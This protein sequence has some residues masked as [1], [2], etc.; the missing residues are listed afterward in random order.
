M[1]ERSIARGMDEVNRLSDVLLLPKMVREEAAIIYR[2]AVKAGLIRG[3]TVLA[4]AAASV[5]AA[6]R[7]RGFRGALRRLRA[8]ARPR[9]RRCG[10]AIGQ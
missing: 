2:R 5:Y 7:L 9:R 1:K 3:R 4:M 8:P 10:G 6:C